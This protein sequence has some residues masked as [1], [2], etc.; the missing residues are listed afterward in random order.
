VKVLIVTTSFSPP[1]ELACRARSASA[2]VPA[3]GEAAE[4][5]R[6]V[7]AGMPVSLAWK[8][9]RSRRARAREFAE[10]LGSVT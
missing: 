7:G 1:E 3:R 5:P 8:E 4:L 9:R 10:I 2:A 6:T